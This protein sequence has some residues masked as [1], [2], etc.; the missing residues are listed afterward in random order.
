MLVLL[1][2]AA[3]L[4]GIC[5]LLYRPSP[6]GGAPGCLLMTLGGLSLVIAAFAALMGA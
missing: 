5:I 1:G 6:E 3:L 4:A 2:I